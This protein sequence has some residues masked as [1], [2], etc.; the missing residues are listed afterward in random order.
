MRSLEGLAS[1]V[2]P[3]RH[4]LAGPAKGS[5]SKLEWTPSDKRA[6]VELKRYLSSTEILQFFD[7]GRETKIVDAS[8]EGLGFMLLQKHRAVWLPTQCGSRL[9]SKAEK[10]YLMVEL[11]ALAA[12]WSVNKC[13]LFLLGIP[14]F[15]LVTDHK[16][17]LSILNNQRLDEIENNRLRRLKSK[18]CNFSY[19]CVWVKGAENY[20]ADAFSRYPTAQPRRGDELG[21]LDVSDHGFS[22]V[23]S[24]YVNR[25]EWQESRMSEIFY[26]DLT[27]RQFK[28]QA[29]E[30]TSYAQLFTY[31]KGGFP[32]GK[33]AL[34]DALKTF[35]KYKL[36][37]S[38]SK[39]LVVFGGGRFSCPAQ[40]LSH[41]WKSCIHGLIWALKNRFHI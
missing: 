41:C 39:G 20:M 21:K 6:F 25:V 17:L 23:S 24:L 32:D 22:P 2:E 9:L 26:E 10:N 36:D 8:R 35:W 1:R 33:G 12:A 15:T 16:P 19:T 37:L 13:R 34:P 4:H 38:L 14:H 11:E 28:N 30:D 31:V 7:L 40:A 3:L 5:A 27:L 18:L 29:Y